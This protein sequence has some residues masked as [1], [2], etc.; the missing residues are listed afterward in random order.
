MSL[1]QCAPLVER[2]QKEGW[3]IAQLNTNGATY[4]LTR[5]IVETAEEERAPVIL[6]AYAA[7]AQYRGLPYCA[8]HMRFM[9]EK[10]DVPVAVHLDHGKSVEICAEAVEAGFTSVMYDGS[11]LPV[12][13]NIANTI[14]VVEKSSTTDASV[15]AEVGQLQDDDSAGE[16]GENLSDPDEIRRMCEETEIDFLAVGIGTAHGFYDVEPNVHLD[17]LAEL[18]EISSVPL[19][20]HGTTGLNDDVVRACIA[21]GIAKVNVGTLIRTR[22]VEYTREAIEAGSHDGHPWRVSREAMNRVK[23]DVRYVLRLTGSSGKC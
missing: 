16:K 5:A 1:S 8:Q 17:L 12:D 20:L 9:A 4:G 21:R 14:Q 7:N 13:E 11:K 18:D 6:G 15:E 2:A 22:Y 10:T 23:E 3:A 19:V